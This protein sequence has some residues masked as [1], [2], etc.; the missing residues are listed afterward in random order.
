MEEINTKQEVAI[1]ELQKDICYIRRSVDEQNNTLLS[2]IKEAPK[3]FASK[4][5]EKIVYGLVGIIIITVATA[6][7]ASVVSAAAIIT[8]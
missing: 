5:S 6:L 8:R 7:V 2:F 1:A 3:C 4:L